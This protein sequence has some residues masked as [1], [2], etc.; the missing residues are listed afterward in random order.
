MKLPDK[1]TPEQHAAIQKFLQIAAQFGAE[2]ERAER[3][4]QEQKVEGNQLACHS[5]TAVE[6]R[7]KS[8]RVS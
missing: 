6:S 3:E 5:A 8:P 2:I 4:Q 1:L 7:E